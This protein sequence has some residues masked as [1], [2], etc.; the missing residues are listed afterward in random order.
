MQNVGFANVDAGILELLRFEIAEVCRV[1]GTPQSLIGHH[2]KGSSIRNA[3]IVTADFVSLKKRALLP[4]AESWIAEIDRKLVRPAARRESLRTGQLRDLSFKYDFRKLDEAS[5]MENV[6]V[7]KNALQ[8]GAVTPNETRKRYFGLAP[9]EGGDDLPL[10]T[11]GGPASP[12]ATSP[13]DG[14]IGVVL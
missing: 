13:E 14:E 6:M 3:N 1:Y 5:E 10:T 4:Y 2:E 12:S 9:L 11:G 7:A 8:S